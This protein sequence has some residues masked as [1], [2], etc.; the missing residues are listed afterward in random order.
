MH[1]LAP[2]PTHDDP[3]VSVRPPFFLSSFVW[4][5]PTHP[6]ATLDNNNNW[7]ERG[8]RDSQARVNK[9]TSRCSCCLPSFLRPFPLLKKHRTHPLLSIHHCFAPLP[10]VCCGGNRT[11]RSS[12]SQMLL[13][14]FPFPCLPLGRA[15]KKTREK[16]TRSPKVFLFETFCFLFVSF[17]LFWRVT[18]L[19]RSRCY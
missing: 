12:S 11:R 7:K 17:L 2:T 14:F 1:A 4:G 5:A 19:Q 9:K 10:T 6:S 16:K 15:A 3:I 18:F 8:K 13:V